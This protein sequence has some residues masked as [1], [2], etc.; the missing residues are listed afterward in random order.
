MDSALLIGQRSGQPE[1]QLPIR[2]AD[3]SS[4]HTVSAAADFSATNS[5]RG[6]HWRRV[7]IIQ[8]TNS[9]SGSG[10]DYGSR[11]PLRRSLGR[12]GKQLVVARTEPQV[13]VVLGSSVHHAIYDSR[14]SQDRTI[15]VIRPKGGAGG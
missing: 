10:V 4:T 14:S 6:L 8:P 9:S 13:G 15:G 11:I 12:E 1:E 3:A 2:S 5:V 7:N